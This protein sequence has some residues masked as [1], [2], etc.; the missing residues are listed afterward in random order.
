MVQVAQCLP[1]KYEARNSNPITTKEKE[2]ILF[3]NHPFII[4]VDWATAKYQSLLIYIP[5]WFMKYGSLN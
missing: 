4:R 1:S 3:H 2:L 5:H